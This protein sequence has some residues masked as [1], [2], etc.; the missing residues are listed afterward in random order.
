MYSGNAG[1]SKT[2]NECL[3]LKVWFNVG[4]ETAGKVTE[5]MGSEGEVA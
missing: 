5:A 1:E 3:R 2:F 4:I